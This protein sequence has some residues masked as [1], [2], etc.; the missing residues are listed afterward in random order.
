ME[1]GAGRNSQGVLWN[2]YAPI[3]RAEPQNR[4]KIKK[5]KSKDYFYRDLFFSLHEKGTFTEYP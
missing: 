1:L 5:L 3:R 4:A 2:C